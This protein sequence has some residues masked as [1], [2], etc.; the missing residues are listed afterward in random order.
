MFGAAVAIAVMAIVFAVVLDDSPLL[1]FVL[2]GSALCT[3]IA[4]LT[5]LDDYS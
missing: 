5:G 4:I 1:A 2:V 3:Y